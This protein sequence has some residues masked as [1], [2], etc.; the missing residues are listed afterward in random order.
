M[1]SRR[2]STTTLILSLA[3]AL[4]LAP[5]PARAEG[6]EA[7]ADITSSTMDET[8]SSTT[9]ATVDSR[10][11]ANVHESDVANIE[12]I[13]DQDASSTS[14]VAA[15]TEA[16]TEMSGPEDVSDSSEDGD[17]EERDQATPEPETDATGNDEENPTPD[18]SDD[19]RFAGIDT[20]LTAAN[21]DHIRSWTR[22]WGQ[23]AYDTMQAILRAD[24]AFP[25]G[26]GGTVIVA[27][28]EG[29]WDALSAAG[30][31]GLSGAPILITAS[32]A[33]SPQTKA[34]IAR[35]KP[36]RILVMGGSNALSD[37]CFAQ[38]KAL[39]PKDTQRIWGRHA[40]DT[41]VEI[42]K[43]GKDWSKTAIVATSAGYWDALSI[44]PYAYSRHAP[45]FLT[46]SSVN[47]DSRILSDSS[48][49]AIKAGGFERVIIVGGPIAVP[50]SVEGQ[51]TGIGIPA[52][53]VQRIYG[54]V[55]LDTSAEIAK[56]EVK[57]EKMS[58]D[59]LSVATSN[60]YWDALTGAAL[61]GKQDSI[62]VLVNPDGDYRALDAVYGYDGSVTNGHVYGGNIAIAD[63]VFDRIS[64]NFGVS[65]TARESTIQQG[66]ATRLTGTT[67]GNAPN[68]RYDWVWV[69][70]GNGE[71]GRATGSSFDF[72]PPLSGTYRVTCTVT[73]GEE[74]HSVS[75]RI[76]VRQN[77][78]ESYAAANALQRKVV[79]SARRVPSPG[80]GL[81]SEW[82]GEVFG[83]AGMRYIGD[84]DACD[85]CRNYC[86]TTDR[87]ELKVGMVLAVTSHPHTIMGYIYGHIAI[88]IGDG[89]VMDNVGV[90]RTKTLDEWVSHYGASEPVKWGWY[91]NRPLA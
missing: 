80:P 36:T 25:N 10:E 49:S 61:T 86:H 29:Y 2:T 64:G 84:Q 8:A 85:M 6:N 34:E 68:A 75:T 16:Q 76:N 67:V 57:N 1:Y 79:E 74:S 18:V 54:E 30:L 51:L 66:S 87:N 70:D 81:C 72:K 62:L 65:V 46:N 60:G 17:A 9:D 40:D 48:L 12:P 90:I 21:A 82:V 15:E 47:S 58:L 28:G 39:C 37:T 69:R 44:A 43:A 33:L 5:A 78:P 77:G 4:S 32:S 35:I 22:L 55:A 52:T 24:G 42:F 56:W 38:I 26:S 13:A 41:A 71:T 20:E 27:T 31:A 50:A 23:T 3:L 63:E 59:N 89:Q 45:I 88:Y 11:Q 7:P 14:S 73:S 19:E 53:A 91:D 83:D